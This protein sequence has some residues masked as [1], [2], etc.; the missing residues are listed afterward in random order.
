MF[1]N[2]RLFFEIHSWVVHLASDW[3][4]Q[5]SEDLTDDLELEIFR[6]VDAGSANKPN[7]VS[8]QHDG[9][10]T[11]TFEILSG[12]GWLHQVIPV[13]CTV[14]RGAS[15]KVVRESIAEYLTAMVTAAQSV[16][17]YQPAYFGAVTASQEVE[18][19]VV[20]VASAGSER[21]V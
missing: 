12:I 13:A 3:T 14:A 1:K 2:D 8:M 16:Y 7:W 17:A 19:P 11:V 15:R 6:A 20:Y 4:A 5:Q 10:A 9:R 21:A 18:S